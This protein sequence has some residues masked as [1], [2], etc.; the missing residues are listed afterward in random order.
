MQEQSGFKSEHTSVI[1]DAV[2]GGQGLAPLLKVWVSR[3]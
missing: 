3:R 2:I 1:L